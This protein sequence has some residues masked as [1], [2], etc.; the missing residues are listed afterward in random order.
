[1]P[2]ILQE[3][4]DALDTGIKQVLD[5]LRQLQKGDEPIDFGG[6]LNYAFS[7]IL[8]QVYGTRYSQMAQAVSVLEMCK[9]EYYRKVCAPYE[10]QKEYSNGPVLP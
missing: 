1:M 8:M 7:S 4:R 3:H 10:N 9:L 6:C 5:G 2:Y